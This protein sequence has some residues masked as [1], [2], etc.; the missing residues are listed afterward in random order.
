MAPKKAKKK[1]PP[2]PTELRVKVEEI[3]EV[4]QRGRSKG[5]AVS[6]PKTKKKKKGRSSSAVL[7]SSQLTSTKKALLKKKAKKTRSQSFSAGDDGELEE[8]FLVETQKQV[9]LSMYVKQAQIDLEFG[10]H[11]TSLYNYA[12]AVKDLLDMMQSKKTSA[13]KLNKLFGAVSTAQVLCG[14][15]SAALG[16]TL[17]VLSAGTATP[18]VVAGIAVAISGGGMGF[19]GGLA[20]ARRDELM[21]EAP[22]R[23]SN[24]AWESAKKD[25]V[26][27]IKRGAMISTASQG[28]K[29]GSAGLA[30]LG[31][32]GFDV[33]TAVSGG[34]TGALGGGY[35]MYQ[36]IGRVSDSTKFTPNQIWAAASNIFEIHRRNLD[37]LGYAV[38]RS[39]GNPNLQP[40][41]TKKAN[42]MV[43]NSCYQHTS[44]VESLLGDL[45]RQPDTPPE[46]PKVLFPEVIGKRNKE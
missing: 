17:I 42:F 24:T 4:P 29:Y 38:R 10:D 36:G 5:I 33:A 12:A 9:V 18:F 46:I 19:T 2:P 16:V 44:V 32:A 13:K 8:L 15:A 7:S 35:A 22:L 27:R 39:I 31:G 30:T 20:R 43:L 40:W 14:A 34:V 41:M 23:L 28:V 25:G 37:T 3:G 45:I 26:P 21:D 11:V 1:K 6:L